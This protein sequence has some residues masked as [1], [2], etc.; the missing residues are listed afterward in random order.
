MRAVNELGQ[1]WHKHNELME[2]FE[3]LFPHCFISS[4]KTIRFIRKTWAK[5]KLK[6]IQ[7]DTVQQYMEKA[8]KKLK[9]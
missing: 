9:I 3:F 6:R 1:D 8:L 4:N 2:A 7:V 5:Q